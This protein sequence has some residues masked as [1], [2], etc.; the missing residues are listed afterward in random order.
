[1][2]PAP[3]GELLPARDCRIDIV[4][5]DLDAEAPPAGAL[6][7]KNGRSAA[8]KGI[9]HRIAPLRRIE[10]RVR[11][12]TDRLDGRMQLENSLAPFAGQVIGTGIIPDIGAVAAEPAKLDI[13]AMRLLAVAKHEDELMPRTV[14]RTHSPVALHPDAEV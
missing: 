10:Q 13:V 2:G 4:W 11:D 9:E 8:A 1:M 3:A 7:G 5:V 6:G 14:E 12:E